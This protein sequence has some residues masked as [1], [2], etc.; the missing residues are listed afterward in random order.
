MTCGS[1]G[2]QDQPR[3]C[4]GIRRLRTT[5]LI[6]SHP[7]AIQITL[8]R[9]KVLVGE[10]GTRPGS[11][12]L[13]FRDRDGQCSLFDNSPKIVAAQMNPQPGTASRMGAGSRT[14]PRRSRSR[15][16][17]RTVSS[18]ARVTSFADLQLCSAIIDRLAFAVNIL[19]A[20]TQI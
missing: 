1:T 8:L 11:I 2:T 12:R 5:L 19:E 3:P 10:L 7:V 9:A 18:R 16:L 14:S 6:V 20:G 13:V 4:T 15:A 17:K